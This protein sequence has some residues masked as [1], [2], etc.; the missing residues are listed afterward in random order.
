MYNFQADSVAFMPIL[1]A[2]TQAYST[3]WELISWKILLSEW[4]L[5]IKEHHGE[6]S[7]L[8]S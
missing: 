7:C 6:G 3:S 2:I 4:K 8:C 1:V 5:K